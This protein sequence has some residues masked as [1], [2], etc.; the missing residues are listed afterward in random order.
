MAMDKNDKLHLF[1]KVPQ[2]TPEESLDIQDKIDFV[3]IQIL[4]RKKMLWRENVTVKSAEVWA[5][6]NDKDANQAAE[7]AVANV[8]PTM[9]SLKL[10]I[11]ALQKIKK[12]LEKEFDNGAKDPVE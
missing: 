4:E 3:D 2:I 11:K 12:D 10:E 1:R 6:E 7:N 9:K 5:D 8:V